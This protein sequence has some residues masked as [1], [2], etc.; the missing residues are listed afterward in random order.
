MDV[1]NYYNVGGF[2]SPNKSDLVKPVELTDE[3][4]QAL[5]AFLNSLTGTKR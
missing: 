1:V 2:Y 5:V 4:K 3:E